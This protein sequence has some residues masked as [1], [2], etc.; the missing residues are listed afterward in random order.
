MHTH[1]ETPRDQILWNILFS[2]FFLILIVS[3]FWWRTNGLDTFGWLYL[4]DI[5]DIVLLSLA[6][7]RMIRLVSFDKIFTFARNLFLVQQE[8]GSYKK[9]GGGPRRTIAELLECLWCTGIWSA[10]FTVMLYFGSSVGR[11]VVF[12]LAVAALG[13]FLILLSQMIGR[14]GK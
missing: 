13:S 3:F 2:I 9:S 4:I 5:T 8:D 6:T 7:F 14:L 1:N 12:I 11:F 10:L